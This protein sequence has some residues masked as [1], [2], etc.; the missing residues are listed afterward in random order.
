MSL[1]SV[2]QGYVEDENA[3]ELEA[4]IKETKSLWGLARVRELQLTS[5]ALSVVTLRSPLLCVREVCLTLICR[6]PSLRSVAKGRY[7]LICVDKVY[8]GRPPDCCSSSRGP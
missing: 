3:D 2:A 1:S 6:N 4:T 5:L 7:S 8:D